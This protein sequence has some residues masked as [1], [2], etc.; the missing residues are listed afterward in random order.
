MLLDEGGSVQSWKIQ[1]P[2]DWNGSWAS[3]NDVELAWHVYLGGLD[4]GFNYYGG[5]GN[6]DEVKQA[7]ATT[8]A[9]EKL[10][11][12]VNSRLIDDP[13]RDQTPPSVLRPQRFPWNPGSYTFGWFNSIPGGDNRYLKEMPSEFYIW[14]HAYDISGITS[15]NVKVRVD[16]DGANSMDNDHNETYTGGGDV[17]SWVTIPMAKR[18]LPNTREA[19]NAAANNGQIDYFITPPELADYYFSKITENNMSGFRGKLLDYYIEAV[20]GQGNISKSD[21]QHVFVENDG[22]APPVQ[23]TALNATA[24]S[25]TRISLSWSAVSGAETYIVKRNGAEVGASASA[26]FADIGLMPSTSYSYTVTARNSAGDSPESSG[27]GAT[28]WDPP[29]VPDA[30]TGLTATAVSSD[31]INLTWEPVD[32]EAFYMIRRGGVQVGVSDTHSFSDTDLAPV[33]T[34]SYTVMASNSAGVS[35]ESTPA[36]AATPAA[37]QNFVMDGAVDFAGYQVLDSGMSLYAALRGSRLYVA[38]ASPAGTGYDHFILVSD[39]LLPSATDPAPWAKDGTV[40]V[41]A[42]KPYLAS[43]GGNA[44]AGWY[45]AVDS[46]LANSAGAALEGSIDLDAQFGS[47]PPTVYLAVVAYHTPDGGAI[48]LQAP[49]GNEDGNL[50]PGEWMAFPIGAL[51]DSWANGT[52]DRLDPARD[53]RVSLNWSGASPALYWLCVPGKEYQ[54]EYC[55]SLGDD[56]LPEGTTIEAANGQE[57]MSSPVQNVE[58]Q[59]FLRAR[60]VTP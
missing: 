28:T 20:D 25:S 30:P 8:R 60:L 6:D 57:E 27:A 54:P 41:A 39:A 31:Q 3:P 37:P 44:Y 13:T 36:T 29:T 16:N 46:G 23:P 10:S 55:R 59:R 50:D 9:I 58:T 48:A 17:G 56:W 52:F 38:T 2:Y 47:V 51:R 14:T 19:L 1:A 15:I 32:G 7:L 40:A 18:V 12:F 33:T 35:A 5:L 53:F 4:S 22:V 26:S 21:I 45:N 11:T 24:V 43:E 34:Y 42:T 49:S